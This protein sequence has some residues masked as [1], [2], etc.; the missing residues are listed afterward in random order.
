MDIVY[1]REGRDSMA[2]SSIFTNIVIKDCE[3]AERFV[4]AVEK[5]MAAAKKEEP[6]EIESHDMTREEIRASREQILQ[7]CG[8]KK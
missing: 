3:A 1:A 4:N 8:L 2:T 6:W 5:A 7:S